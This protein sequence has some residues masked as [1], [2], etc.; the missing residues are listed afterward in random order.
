MQLSLADQKANRSWVTRLPEV[1]FAPE[2]LPTFRMGGGLAKTVCRRTRTPG[3]SQRHL[4][5]QGNP[6]HNR[7][8]PATWSQPPGRGEIEPERA[9]STRPA[10]IPRLEARD[11]PLKPTCT[12][13]GSGH[14]E[15]RRCLQAWKKRIRPAAEIRREFGQSLTREE[16]IRMRLARK[17]MWIAAWQSQWLRPSCAP[18]VEPPP[19]P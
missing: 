13:A 6:R 14:R 3:L 12:H 9:A 10:L 16:Y 2:R 1:M 4:R 7:P 11:R 15:A 18:C 19:A 8:V 17:L 5:V